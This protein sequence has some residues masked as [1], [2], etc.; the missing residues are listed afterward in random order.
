MTDFDTIDYFTDPTLVDDP[1]PYYDHLRQQCPVTKMPVYGV[2]AVTGYD[3][4]SEVFRDADTYSNAITP[5]GP[6]PGLP[7]EPEGD[8][9]SEQ[10]EAH[11]DQLPLSEHLVTFDPPQHQRTRALLGKLFTPRRIKESED[12]LWGL[13]DRQIDEFLADGKCELTQA[14]AQPFAMLTVANLLGVPEEDFDVFRTHLGAQKP[15]AMSADEAMVANPL[16]FLDSKFSVYIQDRRDNPRD[17]VLTALAESTYPD[18]EVPEVLA[19][20]H[21]ATFLFGAGQDTTARLITSSLRH[22]ADNPELQKQ[23]REDRSLIPNFVEEALRMEGPVKS[24]FRLARRTTNLA[25]VE[26]PAGTT[27]MINPG[28]INRDPRRFEDPH[29][30]DLHRHNAREHLAFGKGI[31][32]C[33]GG[34]LSRA[35]ARVTIERLLDRTENITIS[36]EHH[37]PQGNRHFSYEPTY[38]LRALAELHLEFT[39][40]D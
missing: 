29:E 11:R 35:E 37:G 31:H 36:E 38:I 19:L 15:G 12:F 22:I 5:T 10:L 7:F 20:C 27:I 2:V 21:L 8:D 39:P 24:D 32:S 3:E 40:A 25:G 13:A 14:Y 33:P 26:I 9:I 17:D 18:G 30:F 6:F 23:L 16:E 4:A 1:H 28:A 34:P